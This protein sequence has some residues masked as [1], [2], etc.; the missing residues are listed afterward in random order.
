MY[1]G[2]ISNI[3]CKISPIE[4]EGFNKRPIIIINCFEARVP[5]LHECL[6]HL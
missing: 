4:V 1:K 2:E 6:W 3:I 5:N